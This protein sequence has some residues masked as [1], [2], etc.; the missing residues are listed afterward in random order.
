MTLLESNASLYLIDGDPSA[1]PPRTSAPSFVVYPMRGEQRADQSRIQIVKAWLGDDG[2]THE[3]VYDDIAA[4][5][6]G[7]VWT[8]PDFDPDHEAFYYAGIIE[9]PPP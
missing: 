4:S 7:T 5:E 2:E 3:Q 6:L 1:R 8:D 9:R